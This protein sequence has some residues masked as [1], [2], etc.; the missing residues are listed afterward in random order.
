MKTC[1]RFK[2]QTCA[3]QVN[4]QP[5]DNF[6]KDAKRKDGLTPHCKSCLKV[7]R[8]VNK[9]Q[10]QATI[11]RWRAENP[12]KMKFYRAR[13]SKEIQEKTKQWRLK[14]RLIR[15]Y[16]IS[17]DEWQAMFVAQ[18][19]TCLICDTHAKD[20]KRGLAVD[21]CHDSGKVRGLLCHMCNQAIRLFKES[22][23]RLQKAIAYLGSHDGLQQPIG[24][25]L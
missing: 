7:Y 15:T 9:E 18:G 13:K 21:H 19:G 14:N 10:R 4:P 16:G 20:L 11:K 17:N 24:N 8:D 22:V 23:P 25:R 3:S 5:L 12:D 6:S 1:C 2:N